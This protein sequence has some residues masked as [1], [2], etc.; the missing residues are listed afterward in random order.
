M[1]HYPIDDFIA[2]IQKNLEACPCLVIQAPPGTGKTTRVPPALLN[3]SW[4]KNQKILVLVPRR[5][6]AK[7]AA[8]WV[9]HEKNEA[10]GQSIGYHFRFENVTSSTT[11]IKFVTE[12]MLMRYMMADPLLS[13]VGCVILDEFHERSLHAD[14]ALSRL[15]F[16]QK[17]KRPDLRLIVMSA[18]LMAE[19]ISRFLQDCPI[20]RIDSK[21]FPVSVSYLSSVSKK[22]KEPLAVLVKEAVLQS[23]KNSHHGHILVFLPGMADIRRV[24]EE[25]L[26]LKKS[27]VLI[28]PLHGDLPKDDQEKIFEETELT[29]IILA[30]N[31]AETSLTIDGVATVID[32]GFSREMSYSW[33]SGTPTLATK[34]ISQAS[35]IQRTGRAGRTG[36]GRCLRLFAQS[37]FQARPAFQKAEILRSDLAQTLLELKALGVDN[38]NEFE[39]FEKP[40]TELITVALNLLFDLGA[41]TH[42]EGQGPLTESGQAM[43]DLPLHP[44]FSCFLLEARKNGVLE[45]ALKIVAVLSE[46]FFEGADIFSVMD[47]KSGFYQERQIRQLRSL[48]SGAHSADK[49]YSHDEV[50]QRLAKCLLTAFPDRVARRRNDDTQKSRS[51]QVELVFCFGGSALV[52]SEFIHDDDDTFVILHVQESKPSGQ[53]RAKP[54]V[55]SLCAIR[56]EWLIDLPQS[57]LQE[58][59]FTRWDA[60]A[61]KVCAGSE[62]VYDQIILSESACD[63]DPIEAVPIFLTQG[64]GFGV[65]SSLPDAR[66]FLHCLS[67]NGVDHD[68]ESL[69][70]RLSLLKKCHPDL[71]LPDFSGSSFHDFL[72][73]IFSGITSLADFKIMDLSHLILGFLSPSVLPVLEKELPRHV[74]LAGGRRVTVHYELDKDPWIESRLQDFFG[75]KMGPVLLG[76]SLPLTLHLLAPNKRAV[77]VTHDLA[78]FWQ[79]TYPELRK[80]LMRRYPRH[81]WP[82]KP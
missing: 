19:A 5:L 34:N 51:V 49:K 27:D 38:L 45:A 18:T 1:S 80:A 50:R 55:L 29:K 9:A 58:K 76:G 22:S 31:I 47:Q 37:D 35:A 46:G 52:S 6:A 68:V 65:G 79:K 72:T 62:L 42:R 36:P 44:R 32:S 28:F 33:W 71:A 15:K 74:V 43:A 66:H 56:P 24:E 12:G 73:R 10:V 70:A 30:T 57:R 64:L 78:S 59:Q 8:T 7:M 14:I 2:D 17:E 23:L 13:E 26:K 75:M 63:P 77:Q 54:R 20:L 82:E 81:A 3:S 21:L 69:F 53:T 48:L 61:K 67:Q 4:L 11:R 41:I 39:F 40:A 60:V 25:L 16:L